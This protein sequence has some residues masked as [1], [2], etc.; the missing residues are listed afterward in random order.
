MKEDCD[1]PCGTPENP[2]KYE[3]DPGPYYVCLKCNKP[4]AIAHDRDHDV[5]EE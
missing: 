2:H 4:W 3:P 1:T 5:I